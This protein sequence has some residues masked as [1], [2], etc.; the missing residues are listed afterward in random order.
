M[1]TALVI[2]HVHFEDLGL[3]EALLLSRGYEIR[4]HD[5]AEPLVAPLALP[6]LLIVL[7]GPIGA[8]DDSDYPFLR[9]ELHLIKRQLD[10]QQPILGICLGAQLL[11]R[12]LGA[13]VQAMAAKEIGFAPLSLTPAGEASEL[14]ALAGVPVLH[15]HGDQFAVPAGARLLAETSAC[16]QAFAFGEHA[17]GLQFHLEVQPARIEQWLVG[18]AHELSSLGLSPQKL[19]DQAR[20]NGERLGAAAKQCLE[21]WLARIAGD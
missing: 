14:G 3:L 6:S 16:P 9:D 12:A 8:F 10:A 1:L 4:Y 21:Q 20:A 11:A 2:R 13:N 19:R 5:V 17:L 7:G 18:H 15:W